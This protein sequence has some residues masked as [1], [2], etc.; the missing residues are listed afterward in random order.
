MKI[1]FILVVVFLMVFG[2]REASTI[3]YTGECVNI[4]CNIKKIRQRDVTDVREINPVIGVDKQ[5][6]VYAEVEFI[7]KCEHDEIININDYYLSIDGKPGSHAYVESVASFV[8][9][10]KIIKKGGKLNIDLYWVLDGAIEDVP[11]SRISLVKKK[12]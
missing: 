8:L 1:R 10:D 2:C 12:Q 4:S 5:T 9:S 7:N 6:Y 3:Y 11:A